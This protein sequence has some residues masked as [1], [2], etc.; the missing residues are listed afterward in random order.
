M[1]DYS[2]KIREEIQELYKEKMEKLN[3]YRAHTSNQL[4]LA[5]IFLSDRG[6]RLL[7]AP[8]EV[9]EN[10]AWCNAAHEVAKNYLDS[11]D[12]E[13]GKAALAA[14]GYLEEVPPECIDNIRQRWS[15]SYRLDTVY[16]KKDP[17]FPVSGEDFKRAERIFINR[18]LERV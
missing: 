7:D 5:G 14:L 3:F 13:L 10:H 18:S 1:S 17:D 4:M 12:K 2:D 8:K 9:V 16:R 6:M 11:K 15:F